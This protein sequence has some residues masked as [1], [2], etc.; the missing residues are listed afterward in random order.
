MRIPYYIVIVFLI[1]SCSLFDTTICNGEYGTGYEID[2]HPSSI[3]LK[4]KSVY[5]HNKTNI[6]YKD[7]ALYHVSLH[8]YKP[9]KEYVLS[10]YKSIES[11]Y[12]EPHVLTF[13]YSLQDIVANSTTIKIPSKNNRSPSHIF[14]KRWFSNDIKS[15][16]ESIPENIFRDTKY[17]FY[18]AFLNGG[19]RKVFFAPDKTGSEFD[20]YKEDEFP[21]PEGK[22][23]RRYKYRDIFVSDTHITLEN[24]KATSNHKV[25][26]EVTLDPFDGKRIKLNTLPIKKIIRQYNEKEFKYKFIRVEDFK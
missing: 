9:N 21:D 2:P 14:L 17:S 19:Q 22:C 7:N 24:E 11:K 3:E 18:L 10:F 26:T 4:N 16:K 6:T 5:F 15:N 13:D 20:Y 25:V 12:K 8:W 23:Y 1:V